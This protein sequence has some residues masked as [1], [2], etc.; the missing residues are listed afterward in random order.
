MVVAAAC[1]R[2]VEAAPPEGPDAELGPTADIALDWQAP[3]T[4]PTE[5]ALLEE[6]AAYRM[7]QA[8]REDRVGVEVQARRID[9][10]TWSAKV[11]IEL[12]GDVVERAFSAE[13]CEVLT[14]GVALLVAVAVD[15]AG[16]SEELEPE[17][18]GD[19]VVSP[20]PPASDE[21]PVEP[22]ASPRPALIG[23]GR[24]YAGGTY[25]DLPGFG[26]ATGAALGMHI[27]PIRWT[28][29][30]RLA[31]EREHRAAAVPAGADFSMWAIDAR[32]CWVVAPR[33][34]PV[35]QLPLCAQGSG[36]QLYA[37]GK[38]LETSR[39]ARAGWGDLGVAAGLL[40]FPVP[41]FA[42]VLEAEGFAALTRPAFTIDDLGELYRPA[43]GGARVWLGVEF[44]W[45]NNLWARRPKGEQ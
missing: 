39:S 14:S 43:A 33:R 8:R 27:G 26:P 10:A 28:L 20:E 2:A 25:G 13:S 18:V 42:F 1:P 45:G 37:R 36:G 11:R 38:D 7:G 34:A 40:V 4:C 19:D 22:P 29:G 21:G 23:V 15:P 24:I 3:S 12:E 44:Q 32:V 31:F 6:I 16:M 41:G 17:E 35:L 5:T 9:D 30:G